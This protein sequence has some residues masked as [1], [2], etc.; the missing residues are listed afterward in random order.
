MSKTIALIISLII[1]YILIGLFWPK[2]FECKTIEIDIE[3]GE[4]LETTAINLKQAGIIR[5]KNF[6][7]SYLFIIGKSTKVK[8]GHYELRTC[9][10][11]VQIGRKITSNQ[12]PDRKFTIIPGWTNAKIARELVANGFIEN[13]EDFTA[14]EGYV[15]PDTYFLNDINILDELIGKA[16]ANFNEKVGEIDYDDLILASIIEK[17]L[18][19]L[20]DK[21]IGAG[22]LFNRLSIGMGLQ[23]DASL[24]Y[25]LNKSS[26]ELTKEDLELDS[27][28]NTYKY[29]GLPPTP[30]CN[31][32]LESIEAV[33]NPAETDYWYYLTTPE[34]ETIFSRT[35]EEHRQAKWEYLK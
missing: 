1:L 26:A 9:D 14:K 20:E 25:V 27:P 8:A 4:V 23:V 12:F 22:V 31:P 11:V 30:I 13:K 2:S 21:K 19:A 34:G 15:L 5:S 33:L 10:N 6:L 16:D 32:S 7:S 28:Y 18:Q 35:L 17:E 29:K 24:T 3:R